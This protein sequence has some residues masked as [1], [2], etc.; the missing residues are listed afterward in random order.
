VSVKKIL[1]IVMMYGVSVSTPYAAETPK[2]GAIAA[3][4]NGQKIMRDEILKQIDAILKKSK[5]ARS[6]TEEEKQKAYSGMLEQMIQMRVL[7]EEAKSSGVA[8]QADFK[9]ALKAQADS[10]LLQFFVKKTQQDMAKS[11]SPEKIQELQKQISEK[12]EQVV[13][14]QMIVKDK[15]TA[16]RIKKAL[17]SGKNFAQLA[18]EYSL[19]KGAK[20]AS[21]PVALSLLPDVL[22]KIIAPLK[23]GQIVL[24]P[25]GSKGETFILQLLKKEKLT[26]PKMLER[27]VFSQIENEYNQNM[28]KDLYKKSKIE[29]FDQD[30]K[31]VSAPA[32]PTQ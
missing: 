24:L 20:T 4:I 12:E 23:P 28:L 26:D 5:D 32:L 1:S 30:G 11:I 15:S 8:S 6:L 3:I 27:I 29:R 21:P 22:Q 31:P 18:K 2:E 14:Q 7:L 19:D 10:L 25:A 9:E 13:I 16:E 17:E